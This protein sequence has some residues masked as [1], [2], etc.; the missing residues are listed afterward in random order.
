MK[1]NIKDNQLIPAIVQDDRTNQV[2]MLAYMNQ[3]ALEITRQSGRVT[4]FSRSRQ[5]LW[6]KGE[7]SGNYLALRSITF[8][9]DRD[10]ILVRAVPAGPACHTGA[11]TCFGPEADSGFMYRLQEVI[12]ERSIEADTESY[13]ARLIEKGTSSIAQKVGEEAVEVV[14]EAMRSDRDKLISE[15]ADLMYHLT[16]LMHSET[17]TWEDV[18]GRLRQRHASNTKAAP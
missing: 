4:F 1:E 13:T 3:E 9:C 15:C 6:T 16:V 14:I 11:H 17:I 8:D 7:Q 12:A 2:L 5:R 18:E 10:T